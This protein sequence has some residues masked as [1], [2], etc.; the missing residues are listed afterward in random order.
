MQFLTSLVGA[1]GNGV[2]NSVLALG[3]VL[4]LIVLGLWV[5]KFVMKAAPLAPRSRRLTVVD[6]LQVDPR[7]RLLIVRRDNVEHL[8]LTGGPQDLLLEAGIPSVERA[9]VPGRRLQVATEERSEETGAATVAAPQ[10]AKAPAP[11]PEPVQTP[12]TPRPR[13][14]RPHLDRLRELGR[15]APTAAVRKPMSLRHTGLLRPV[16]VMEPAVIPMPPMSGD[17]SGRSRSDSATRPVVTDGN[18]R[19]AL[20]GQRKLG[21]IGKAE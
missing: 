21:D 19:S 15:P 14:I 16:S 2:L 20:G 13:V 18:G 12:E 5:L 6:Q 3:I 9:T 1:N 4:V 17:N 8:I 10:S 11:E 7:R